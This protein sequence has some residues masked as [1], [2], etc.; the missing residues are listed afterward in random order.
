ML[1]FRRL[2][3][4]IS[5]QEEIWNLFVLEERFWMLEVKMLYK[6]PI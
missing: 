2:S 6:A 4:L 1:V 5:M 3:K